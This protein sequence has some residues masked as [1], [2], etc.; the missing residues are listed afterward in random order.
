MGNERH[1]LY[2]YVEGS[3]WIFPEKVSTAVIWINAPLTSR[4]KWIVS[5]CATEWDERCS[6]KAALPR[7]NA[8]SSLEAPEAWRSGEVIEHVLYGLLFQQG[9]ATLDPRHVPVAKTFASFAQALP[10]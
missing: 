9:S 5:S 4:P 6:S 2:V 7:L 10:N 3:S 1:C 8:F